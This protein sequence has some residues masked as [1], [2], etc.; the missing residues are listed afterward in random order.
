MRITPLIAFMLLLLS[1]LSCRSNQEITK[2][3]VGSDFLFDPVVSG[4]LG[5]SVMCIIETP[6][7]VYAYKLKPKSSEQDMLIGEYAVDTVIGRL[8]VSYYAPLQFFLKDSAN[9][10][11]ADESVKTPFSPNVGFEFINEKQEK[12]HI[13]LAFNGNQLEVLYQGLVVVHKEFRN[14]YFLLRFVE[15]LLPENQF[16]KRKLLHNYQN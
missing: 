3:F 1:V 6:K 4:W 15:K 13:L 7:E 5:D 10:I 8:D 2:N 12:V 11:L 14:E 16:I 9:Y